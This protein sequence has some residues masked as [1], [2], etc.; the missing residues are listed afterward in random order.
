LGAFLDNGLLGKAILSLGEAD[1][2]H[3]L[4]LALEPQVAVDHLAVVVFDDQLTAHLAGAGSRQ[5]GNVALEAGQLYE[6]ARFYRH[7]PGAKQLGGAGESGE[8]PVLARL[9]ASDIIDPTYR[10]E[11]YDRFRLLE[12]LS[13]VDRV[14]DWWVMLNLYRGRGSESVPSGDSL[15]NRSVGGPFRERDITRIREMAPLLV[16]LAGKHAALAIPT[17]ARRGR[18]DSIRYLDNLLAEIEGRLTPRERAVCAR[19]L[20]GQTVRGIAS[21]LEVRA[22][23]VATLR[24]RA[25][26]KLNISSLNELF[27]RCMEQLARDSLVRK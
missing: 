25:Y 1:F 10:R 8:G 23:T 17:P 14:R 15:A 5:P 9:R 16:G 6:R 22:P 2:A 3:T 20:A 4:L 12:R 24:R 7:D 18:I 27:A 13:I 26:A 11:I 19:A 21:E